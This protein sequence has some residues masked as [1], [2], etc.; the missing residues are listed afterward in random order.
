MSLQSSRLL[1]PLRVTAFFK[2]YPFMPL[3]TN[4]R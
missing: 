1:D 2:P 3:L 4:F